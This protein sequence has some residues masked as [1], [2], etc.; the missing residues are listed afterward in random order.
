[1]TM[2]EIGATAG[3]GVCRLAASENDKAGRDLFIK[4]CE[5][6]GC[7][8]TAD[9][10]G[11]LFARREGKNKDAPPI[12]MGSHLDSQPTGGKF[13]GVYGVLAGLEV[14]R[15]L[16]EFGIETVAPVEVAVWM[17]EEGARFSPAML[18]S[19]VFSGAFGLD[20]GLAREDDAG[21]TLGEALIRNRLA[22][23][24]DV[25]RKLGAHFEAHIEQGPVLENEGKVIGVVTGVQG[26]KW[27]DVTV[28]GAECHAGPTPMHM[29]VDPVQA[30]APLLMKIFT[31]A[32]ANAPD[33]RV[34]VGE[35]HS[36]PS[37][38]NTVPGKVK[39]S[40][41]L[42]HP[43]QSV[44]DAMSRQLEELVRTDS[45]AGC[46]FALEEI[47]H[48][49]PVAF[50]ADCIAAIRNA[51]KAAK[52]PYM[53]LVSGAGHDSVYLSQVAPTGMIFV[54][55]EKGV[56]HNEAES[57]DPAHL[58]AGCN[59]LLRAVLMRAGGNLAVLS[60]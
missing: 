41:D 48:S 54:P 15:T 22:G 36:Y 44:L 14:I 25:G 2:A 58:A 47:W 33:A 3:G 28:S 37:S 35:L 52:Q 40:V 27:F 39:F 17:N 13:D 19:G 5:D 38:R 59:V 56:S 60:R 6:A 53:E 26:I 50:D 43:D 18:G 12:V 1:M 8:V 10:I 16:N 24:L 20:Y 34:T 29:R 42:R 45:A 46:S 21:V 51:A 57:A 23:K 49:P 7:V 9:K 55:C 11:N 4:W 30:M 31:L 32:K